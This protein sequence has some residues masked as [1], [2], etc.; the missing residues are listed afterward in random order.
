[1]KNGLTGQ[2]IADIISK[3]M[4]MPP[5]S[6]WLLDENRLI[7]NDEG[8][9]IIVGMTTSVPMANTVTALEKTIKNKTVIYQV[10]Q[11]QAM[12]TIKIDVLSRSNS[13]RVRNIEALMA[14]KSFYSQQ[15]QE[16]NNFKIFTIP[17]SFI[18]ASGAEGGSNINRYSIS[19]AAMVWYRQ[20]KVLNSPLGDYYDDFTTRADDDNTIGTD[21]PIAEFEI[22]PETPEP[23]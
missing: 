1:M 14:L 5:D 2:I 6:V 13:A 10:S 18:N 19:I 20:E 12:E 16:L 7:P 17:K 15:Q 8:L 23:L 21:Q 4:L 3:E 11:I 9:Y 22:T